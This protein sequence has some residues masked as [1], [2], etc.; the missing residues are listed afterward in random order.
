MIFR[1]GRNR[2]AW[3]KPVQ[4]FEDQ[5]KVAN[6]AIMSNG[7]SGNWAAARIDKTTRRD[8]LIEKTTWSRCWYA[9]SLLNVVLWW[10]VSRQGTAPCLPSTKSSS[11]RIVRIA[12]FFSSGPFLEALAKTDSTAV[13]GTGKAIFN[14]RRERRGGAA[15]ARSA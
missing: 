5:R 1:R 4:I 6:R 7:R 11:C 8:T 2:H 12:A 3:H 13:Y 14:S 10:P 9:F 15:C